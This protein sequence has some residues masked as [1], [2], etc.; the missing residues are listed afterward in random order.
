M[1]EIPNIEYGARWHHERY[2]GK[3]YPDGLK[4]E[5]IPEYARI[6]CVADA[7]DAMTSTR[8]YRAVMSQEKVRNEIENC[9]G[10]QF[11]PII[12]QIMIEMIDED[13]N[14]KMKEK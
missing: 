9:K 10:K 1:T 2:D 7:Y 5:Q 12:A 13:I 14:Y 6:I 3:G 11:D 4:G 8:S